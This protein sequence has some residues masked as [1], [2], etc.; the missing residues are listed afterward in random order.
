ML[1]GVAIRATLGHLA[2]SIFGADMQAYLKAA[3]RRDLFGLEAN[4][5]KRR[6]GP[7]FGYVP[8]RL[9]SAANERFV[10]AHA[11][12]RVDAGRVLKT[13][14]PLNVDVFILST[15][16]LSGPEMASTPSFFTNCATGSSIPDRRLRFR[17]S[18]TMATVLPVRLYTRELT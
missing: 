8:T 13:E 10:D 7:L 11:G 2:S 5:A 16:V 4:L 12:Y 17:C 1:T 6:C 3:D 15:E 14:P 9:L 18:Q